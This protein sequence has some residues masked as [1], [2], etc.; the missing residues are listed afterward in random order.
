MFLLSTIAPDAFVVKLPLI[1]HLHVHSTQL[2][3]RDEWG[4]PIFS[5]AP[6]YI[7]FHNYYRTIVEKQP[8]LLS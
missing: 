1:S 6:Y 4:V 5:N 8:H 2:N 7:T 3:S